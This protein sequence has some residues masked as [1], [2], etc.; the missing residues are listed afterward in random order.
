MRSPGL[1]VALL[2]GGA[3]GAVGTV[4]MTALM[5]AAGRAGLVGRQPPE[6]ITRTAV[7]RATGIEPRGAT[8]D[9]L[10]SLTHLGFGV[11][12][13]VVYA[14]LPAS[15][16]LPAAAR[17]AVY[18][19]AVWAVS[20]LGWVP[21]LLGALPSADRDRPDR[22]AVMVTAHVVYGAVVGTLDGRWRTSPR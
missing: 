19:L 3:A 21:R 7:E 11:G 9:A 13:G 4:A 15:E 17:G 10:S 12:A 20:Y 14:A 16:R 18:G 8:A 2:R 22:V 6:A 5:L 1:G